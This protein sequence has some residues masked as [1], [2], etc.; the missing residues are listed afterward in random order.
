MGYLTVSMQGKFSDVNS[1]V[2]KNGTKLVKGKFL[3][4][5][6]NKNTGEEYEKKV[7]FLAWDE[8]ATYVENWPDG[9]EAKVEGTL[10]TSSFDKACPKCG[11][12]YK[13]F[14]TEVVINSVD[15]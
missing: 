6:A 12:T 14:W 3:I 2:T 13:S 4:T 8:V 7:P 11:D 5:L 10:R 1:M 15:V 9:V